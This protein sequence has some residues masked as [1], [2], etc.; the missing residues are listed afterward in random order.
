MRHSH[1]RRGLFGAALLAEVFIGTP[2]SAASPPPCISRL[3]VELT[4]DIPNP[5]DPEFLSSLLG[6]NP[7]YLLTWVRRY[8]G[9]AIILDLTGPGPREQCDAV[10]DTM[11]RDGRIV[12]VDLDSG[13]MQSVFVFGDATKPGETPRDEDPD[14][15]I[16]REGFGSLEWAVRHPV[17]GWKILLPLEPGDPVRSDIEIEEQ[18][19]SALCLP[20]LDPADEPPGCP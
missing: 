20:N 8:D 1:F 19:G 10:I 3:V 6:N 14:V 12:S 2:A 9:F 5:R 4:P 13:D 7:A 16:S 15:H 18:A 17:Q 11:R